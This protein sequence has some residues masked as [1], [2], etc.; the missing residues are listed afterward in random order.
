MPQTLPLISAA[1][2]LRNR[3]SRPPQGPD[4]TLEPKLI[5]AAGAQTLA[6]LEREVHAVREA[7]F[8]LTDAAHHRISAD[9]TQLHVSLQVVSNELGQIERLLDQA[10]AATPDTASPD[11]AT[12]DTATGS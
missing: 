4:A 3:R 2:R 1:Q 11:T 5:N 8:Q 9:S 6:D 10:R 12:P 7:V